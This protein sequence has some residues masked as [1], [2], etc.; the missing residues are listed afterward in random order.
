[1]HFFALYILNAESVFLCS[2]T[3]E[4]WNLKSW[5]VNSYLFIFWISLKFTSSD[6]VDEINNIMKCFVLFQKQYNETLPVELCEPIKMLED[7][8]LLLAN[9]VE[10]Q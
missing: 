1:M 2:E 7:D 5:I 4:N 9:N 10:T 3:S 8:L 6:C